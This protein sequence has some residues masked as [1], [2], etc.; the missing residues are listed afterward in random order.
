MINPV[1]ET[2]RRLETHIREQNLDRSVILDPHVLASRTS[3]P[4]SAVSALL[5]GSKLPDEPFESRVLAR[6][7]TFMHSYMTEAG[8]TEAQ[9][10]GEVQRSLTISRP[11]A[12][13]VCRGEKVP[14]PKTLHELAVYFELEGQETYFTCT[15]AEAVERALKGILHR[16]EAPQRDPLDA[17][18][19]Q[20][21]V[22]GSDMRLHGSV[23]SKAEF[24]AL[25]EGV[26][27]SVLRPK[28]EEG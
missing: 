14:N 8:K 3:L 1:L 7:R 9:L 11:W 10:I 6:I 4:V 18:M 15:A 21:G 22:V 5:Q 26:F 2:L 13:M 28:K 20:Y 19:E 27:R 16:Y 12:R 24:A 23:G 17:L 25:L